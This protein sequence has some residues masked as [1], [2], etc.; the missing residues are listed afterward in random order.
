VRLVAGDLPRPGPGAL[1]IPA[2]SAHPPSPQHGLLGHVLGIALRSAESPGLA[3][4]VPAKRLPIP[5]RIGSVSNQWTTCNPLEQSAGQVGVATKTAAAAYDT[6]APFYDRFT[7]HH[8]YELWTSGLLRLAYEHGLTGTR[9]LDAG[10]GTGKSFLP[11]LARGFEV[12]ACDQ[13][14]AMLEVAASKTGGAV[15][16][17]CS[18]LRELEPLGEFDLITCLDDVANYLTDPVELGAAL[19]GL[20][21]NLRPGGVLVFDANTLATYRSFFSETVVVE[22]PGL[23]MVWR[24]LAGEDFAPGGLARAVLDVFSEDPDGGEWAR[25][26]I[27]HEQRHHPRSTVDRCVAAAGLRC[28]GVYGQDPAVNV[29]AELDELRHTKAVYLL[30]L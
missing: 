1:R 22:E 25:A 13:S 7:A 15:E 29:D 11:L 23:V 14:P 6:F 16:L 20:A 10:C 19:A 21:G 12:T 2:R 30:S 4:A 27:D 8:D 3:I 28:L 17:H 26:T 18:D 5:V 24:G 9:V